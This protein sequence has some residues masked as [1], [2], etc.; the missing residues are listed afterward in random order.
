MFQSTSANTETWNYNAIGETVSTDHS[1]NNAFDRSFQFDG[2]GNRKKSA[3][4]STLPAT[5]NYTS[6]ALNQ[7]SAVGVVA[8]TFDDDGNPTNDGT[9]Q[10]V[11]DGENRLIT[12]KVGAVTVAEY[13]YDAYSRRI[14]KDVAGVIT[15]FVYDGWNPIAEF[16]GTTLSKSYVWGMDLSGSMQGAG[17][18][19]GLLAVNDTVATYFPIM[20]GTGNVS[21]YVDSTGSVVAH[22]EYSAFGEAVASGTKANDFSHQFSTKQIDSETGFHY[23]GYRYYDSTNG[24]WLGRDP[25]ADEMF[26]QN[27]LNQIG[28]G[29]KKDELY[30]LSGELREVTFKNIYSFIDNSGL[31]SWDYLG[32]KDQKCC[33]EVKD[34]IDGA[35]TDAVGL[36]GDAGKQ[37]A[38]MIKIIG[39]INNGVKQPKKISIACN[40]FTKCATTANCL[41][42]CQAIAEIA[43]GIGRMVLMLECTALCTK[44][45]IGN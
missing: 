7:Y 20:D 4:S 44:I 24:R 25:L 26:F 8:R 3:N 21:E 35:L 13:A 36:G 27:F 41:Q 40:R 23:Y 17:G 16:S 22:Y 30:Q 33:P 38:K 28:S 18:V 31:A 2:I 1:T 14:T 10:F 12:V 34:F 45:P 42:C 29:Y 5:D 19:G 43:G 32:L 9:K 6:N 11:W 37:A 15:N 39:A